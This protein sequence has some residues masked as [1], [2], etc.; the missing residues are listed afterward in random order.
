MFTRL[1]A[2]G[3]V[4]AL[5]TGVVGLVVAPYLIVDVIIFDLFSSV[6]FYYC[7]RN[8][9][10]PRWFTGRGVPTSRSRIL[11]FAAMP[12]VRRFHPLATVKSNPF[13]KALASRQTTRSIS[14]EELEDLRL[15]PSE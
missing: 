11:Q 10:A 7:L 13:E 15:T 5:V 12:K 14:E 2:T 8:A 6:I 9:E 3:A 4:V 1:L